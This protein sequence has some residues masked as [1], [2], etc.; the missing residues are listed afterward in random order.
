MA[1]N[2]IIVFAVAAL[3]VGAAI[4]IGAGA[5]IFKDKSSDDQTYYVYLYAGDNNA[6]N[7]WYSA[8]ASDANGAFDKMF[9][10]EKF[11]FKWSSGYP[12]AAGSSA[13]YEYLWSE[14]TKLAA[15]KS[16]D[17]AGM[18]GDALCGWRQY[19]A[20]G[21][22]DDTEKKMGLSYSNIFFLGI[23]VNTDP[24]DPYAWAPTSPA[25]ITAWK[26]AEGTPFATA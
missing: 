20:S 18:G 19:N 1:D 16:T 22:P 5:L 3:V 15:D 26:T 21:V 8:K 6:L 10:D 9:S 14:T 24:L 17:V 4:G 2:K 12:I 13:I 23:W 11:A 7:G 25:D